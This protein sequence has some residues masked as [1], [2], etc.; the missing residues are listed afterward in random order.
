MRFPFLFTARCAS[1]TSTRAP[2]NLLTKALIFALIFFNKNNGI[3]IPIHFL[4][5]SNTISIQFVK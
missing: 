3:E 5:N 4:N 1:L 2:S